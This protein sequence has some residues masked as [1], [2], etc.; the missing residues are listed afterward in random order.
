MDDI[1]C[2]DCSSNCLECTALSSCTKCEIDY[3]LF[4]GECILNS[5][6]IQNCFDY[7]SIFV[8]G[9]AI[10]LCKTCYNNFFLF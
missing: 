9:S 1:Y 2:Y 8:Q 4:L 10:N 7:E 5:D 6:Y 3:G